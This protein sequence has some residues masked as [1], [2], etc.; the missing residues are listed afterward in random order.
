MRTRAFVLVTLFAGLSF[1]QEDAGAKAFRLGDYAEAERIYRAALFEQ[2]TPAVLRALADLYRTQGKDADAEPLLALHE[3][4][5]GPESVETA[6]SL[7]DLAMTYRNLA[8]SKDAIPLV[9]RAI[10]IHG[11]LL[12][13]IIRCWQRISRISPC[14][15]WTHRSSK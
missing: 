4:T 6:S 10:L 15:S 8:K 2:E 12:A 11:K 7:I 1:A 9:Q 5:S 13:V 14:C 3:E